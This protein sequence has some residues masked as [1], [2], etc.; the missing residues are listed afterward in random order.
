MR[1]FFEN[2]F[3][4]FG[5][6][7]FFLGCII[8]IDVR[9]FANVLSEQGID[10]T[11]AIGFLIVVA[12]IPVSL[13]FISVNFPH[14]IFRSVCWIGWIFIMSYGGAVLTKQPIVMQLD[15][16]INS[17]LVPL[18]LIIS[19]LIVATDGHAIAQKYNLSNKTPPH[20]SIRNSAV[21]LYNIGTYG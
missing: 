20:C 6:F 12:A 13:V 14:R 7:F 3:T 11:T 15:W 19:G 18:S 1:S 10:S 16:S 9:A 17:V 21:L 4:I 8:C 2:L 5:A